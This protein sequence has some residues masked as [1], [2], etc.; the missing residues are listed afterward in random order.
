MKQAASDWDLP[1]ICLPWGYPAPQPQVL[2]HQKPSLGTSL[3]VQWLRLGAPNAGDL[4]SIPGQA[5]R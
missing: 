1:S 4:G 3:V 2:A 5:I